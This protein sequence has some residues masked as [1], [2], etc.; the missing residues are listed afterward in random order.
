MQMENA[1]TQHEERN[2]DNGKEV[3]MRKAT[4]QLKMNKH[5]QRPIGLN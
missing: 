3:A 1:T 4:I 2:M 5:K